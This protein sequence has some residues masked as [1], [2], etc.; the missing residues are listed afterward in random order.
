MKNWEEVQLLLEQ[1]FYVI[2]IKNYKILI[3]FKLKV[4]FEFK[5][6]YA[7]LNSMNVIFGFLFSIISITA[8]GFVI[9]YEKQLFKDYYVHRTEYLGNKGTNA[10][11][12][13]V[14][15]FFLLSMLSSN[16]IDFENYFN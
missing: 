12:I 8:L 16:F 14:V 3:L 13:S 7:Y 2:L 6:Q 11:I 5:N 9:V 4:I 10:L 1:L 15:L